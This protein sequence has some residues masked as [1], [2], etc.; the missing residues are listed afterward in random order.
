ME[1]G[2][3]LVLESEPTSN[4]TSFFTMK[5]K[6]TAPVVNIP[7]WTNRN[8]HG[9]EQGSN[10]SNG[11]NTEGSD[12]RDNRF[13]GRDGEVAA[14]DEEGGGG[15]RVVVDFFNKKRGR[16]EDDRVVK[17]EISDLGAQKSDAVVNTGLQLT[18]TVANARSDQSTVDD[19]VL[20]DT[21]DKRTKN[22][23]AML[24]IEIQR[25]NAENQRLKGMLSQVSNNYSALQLQLVAMMQQKHKDEDQNKVVQAKSEKADHMVARQFLDLGHP[26]VET[27]EKTDQSQTS[28]DE[29][30]LDQSDSPRVNTGATVSHAGREESPGSEDQAWGSNKIPKLNNAKVVEQAADAT[31]RK[32]RVS[33]RARSEAPMISDG[34]QWRKYG[35]KMAKGNPCPRA[36][37]R[38]T[39]AVGCPV[40]KQVQRCAEDKSIL[41]TTYE[42]SHNHPLPPA[43]MAMASTTSAAASMLLSGSMSSAE[44][45]MNPNILARTILPCSSNNMATI[46]ASAPFP[47]VTLDL[48]NNTTTSQNIPLQFQRPQFQV[49]FDGQLPQSFGSVLPQMF[50]QS[51]FSGL[52]SSQDQSQ[53]LYHQLKQQ[54]VSQSQAANSL[55]ADTISA[56]TA[57]I[58]SDPNFTAAVAA[59]ISSYIVAGGNGGGGGTSS[60]KNVADVMTA[61]SGL[62]N[63]SCSNSSMQQH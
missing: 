31:M 59:A 8:N 56:A 52:H 28:S 29:R 49:P 10:N 14:E 20:S 16:E 1:R 53:L 11:N 39:M 61:T 19:G 47:T 41:I 30:T 50:S 21:D 51:K 35:Q 43:A 48:T 44:G 33:V 46:S 22:E 62:G 42:G 17:K 54:L 3:G 27:A 15:R 2:S 26:I 63:G 24:N 40:R 4:L 32:V 6:L 60:D 25:M 37:Y 18:T 55:S 38:C 23:L 45:I 58:A 57:A 9:S 13:K 5:Q 34:C 36:Y 7:F 12:H